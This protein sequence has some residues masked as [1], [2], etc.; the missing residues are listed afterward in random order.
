M[1]R[2]PAAHP[3]HDLLRVFEIESLYLLL[4]AERSRAMLR[5]VRTVIV[6]EIHAV[7]DSRGFPF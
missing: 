7:I 3:G 1:L 2:T 5:T 6:D 4:T